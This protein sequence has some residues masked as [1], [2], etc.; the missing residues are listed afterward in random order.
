MSRKNGLTLRIT[1]PD[2][3]VTESTSQ[4]ESVIVG[5]GPGAAVKITDPKVSNLHVMLKVEKNGVVTA[6]DLGSENGTRVGNN[7]VSR[8]PVS[9]TS[10]DTLFVGGTQ[11][12]V[13]FDDQ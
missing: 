8:D 13:L 6:I 10:G 1:H 2:G 12:K 11:V 7:N 5:S 4:L 9:L 3:T